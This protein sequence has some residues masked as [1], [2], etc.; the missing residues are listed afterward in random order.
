MQPELF[1]PP[2]SMNC[3][4]LQMLDMAEVNGCLEQCNCVLVVQMLHMAEVNG[5]LEQCN[6]VLVVAP[7]AMVSAS[8]RVPDRLCRL[9]HK[10]GIMQ[11]AQN[12]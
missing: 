5:C 4:T 11:E 2:K 3:H 10:R 7:E 6:C 1:R 8:L 12:P 9:G